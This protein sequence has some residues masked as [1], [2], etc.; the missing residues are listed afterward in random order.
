MRACAWGRMAEWL[1]KDACIPNDG[2]LI[3]E[4]T[5]PQYKF[6]SDGRMQL[7]SKADIKK[8]GNP[9]PDKAD[10]LALTFSILIGFPEEMGDGYSLESEVGEDKPQPKT[11]WDYDPYQDF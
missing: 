11:D 3:S 8:R 9:S 1:K 2:E 7:E 5:A 6:S 10:A 4:L